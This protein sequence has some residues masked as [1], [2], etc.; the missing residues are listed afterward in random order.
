MHP[1]ENLFGPYK[2]AGLPKNPSAK[3]ATRDD[4]H[5]GKP[6]DD[7]DRDN[8]HPPSSS[9][10]RSLGITPGEIRLKASFDV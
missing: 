9:H 8:I 4:Y 10:V 1:F 5:H 6:L 7:D 2:T 3:L